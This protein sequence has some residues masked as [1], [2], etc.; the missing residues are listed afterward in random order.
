MNKISK[1]ALLIFSLTALLSVN[2]YA[3][4]KAILLKINNKTDLTLLTT[5]SSSKNMKHMKGINKQIFSPWREKTKYLE[6][7]R[8]GT[9][10]FEI[11]VY[12]VT[13]R[14]LLIMLGTL[15]FTSE[16]RSRGDDKTWTCPRSAPYFYSVGD[17]YCFKFIPTLEK[18]YSTFNVRANNQFHVTLTFEK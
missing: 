16:D 2:A 12:K 13:K 5:L 14:K 17:I 11:N 4:T 7:T 1:F 10:K 8:F 9:S 3:L 18:P 6:T 15:N